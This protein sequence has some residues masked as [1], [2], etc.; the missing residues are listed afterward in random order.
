MRSHGEPDFPDPSPNGTLNITNNPNDPQLQAAQRACLHLL[1]GGGNQTTG[2][3]FTPAEV[4][5]VLNFSR[6]MRAHGIVTYPDPT[7]NGMGSLKGIDPNSPQFNT[8]MQACQSL[9]PHLGGNGPV[10]GS[11]SGS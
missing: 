6:C 4:A 3:H 2:G 5:Q 1:P 10:T 8:A 9:M 7:A 11:G